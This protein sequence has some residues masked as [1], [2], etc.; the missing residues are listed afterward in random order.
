MGCTDRVYFG[1]LQSL[2]RGEARNYAVI[3]VCTLAAPS[4]C[5]LHVFRRTTVCGG[6][7]LVFL[8]TGT[9][10]G[11]RSVYVFRKAFAP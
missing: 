11:P 6:A 4:R 10:K 7:I 2:P 3:M 5:F 8:V 1:L 9:R